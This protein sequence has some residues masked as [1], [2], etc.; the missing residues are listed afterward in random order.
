MTYCILNQKE[1]REEA[2]KRI[3][4]KKA[5]KLITLSIFLNQREKS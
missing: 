2:A 4:L 3:L 5:A 1:E